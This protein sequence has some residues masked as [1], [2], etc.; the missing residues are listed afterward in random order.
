MSDN[1]FRSLLP[2]KSKITK[3]DIADTSNFK[4]QDKARRRLNEV[5]LGCPPT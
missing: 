3:T 4:L 5:A 1:I 2:A